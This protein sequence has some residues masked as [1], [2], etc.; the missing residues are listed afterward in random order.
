MRREQ[1]RQIV[2]GQVE[3]TCRAARRDAAFVN[4]EGDHFHERL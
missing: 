2:N 3:Q 1:V 4:G